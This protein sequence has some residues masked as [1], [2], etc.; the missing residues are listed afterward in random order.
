MYFCLQVYFTT[1]LS[2]KEYFIRLLFNFGYK[3]YVASSYDTEQ[4]LSFKLPLKLEIFY[5]Y[6]RFCIDQKKETLIILDCENITI[7]YNTHI[8]LLQM[9][10][11]KYTKKFQTI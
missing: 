2:K 7:I 8:Y 5:S 6:I 3:S 10:H 4:I 1:F 11:L 9:V